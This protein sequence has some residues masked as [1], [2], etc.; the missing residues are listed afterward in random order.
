MASSSSSSS[1]TSKRK[2]QEPAPAR[3]SREQYLLLHP[4]QEV[5]WATMSRQQTS[6]Y[7]ALASADRL[8]HYKELEQ[9]V[10]SGI[11]EG[12]VEP[13]SAASAKRQKGENKNENKLS[14]QINNGLLQSVILRLKEK[15]SMPI[16]EPA[17]GRFYRSPFSEIIDEITDFFPLSYKL[18]VTVA[19]ANALHLVCRIPSD[20][21]SHKS[22]DSRIM[23]LGKRM[24]SVGADPTYRDPIESVICVA[25]K[26]GWMSIAKWIMGNYP[27]AY[28]VEEDLGQT[29]LAHP[30]CRDV[31]RITHAAF[32]TFAVDTERWFESVLLFDK[33]AIQIILAGYLDW[34]YLSPASSAAPP[35]QAICQHRQWIRTLGGHQCLDCG[36]HLARTLLTPTQTPLE[37]FSDD[38]DDDDTV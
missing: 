19:P 21:R 2:L 36:M 1:S 37:V 26:N 23:R 20:S 22:M 34:D 31:Y 12:W 16:A 18:K 35:T 14:Q 5:Q 29:L 4:G 33:K 28:L 25:L 8:R 15:L 9:V 10:R 27:T 32:C 11:D 3:R 17:R 7:N 38:D 13:H 6:A 24:V 30:Q